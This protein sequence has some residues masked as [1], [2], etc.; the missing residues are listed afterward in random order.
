M[1]ILLTILCIILIYTHP[2]LE[3][4]LRHAKVYG[5]RLM[6]RASQHLGGL[7]WKKSTLVLLLTSKH[8]RPGSFVDTPR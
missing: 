7:P 6:V 4:Y 8:S 3:L 1:Q 2:L 5:K